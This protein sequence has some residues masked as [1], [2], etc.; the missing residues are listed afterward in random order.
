MSG[1]VAIL[2]VLSDRPGLAV[3]FILAAALFDF[4]D[5]TAARLLKST[6][7]I[8]KQLDSLADIVSFGLV[9]AAFLYKIIQYLL[10][11]EQD[12]PFWS[13]PVVSVVALAS[14]LIVPVFSAIRLARFNTQK[15][16]GDFLGLP[17]PAYALFW[18]GIYYDVIING[19]LYGQNIS[20]WF[21][22]VIMIGLAGLM[23]IPLPMISL[24]FTDLKL[25]NNVF[26]YLTLLL[27]IFMLIILHIPGLPVLIL[28]YILLSLVRIV[29]T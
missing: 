12:D 13:G 18:T 24:K 5:G 11:I 28:I 23:I 29:L 14:I 22:L 10:G 19:S 9:P 1:T 21:T 8:G 2:M 15:P 3:I 25:R 17:V 27:G 7:E 16:G 26:R 6:S 4:L 20:I